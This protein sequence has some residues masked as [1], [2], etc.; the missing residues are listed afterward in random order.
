MFGQVQLTTETPANSA[1]SVEGRLSD[2]MYIPR[3]GTPSSLAVLISHNSPVAF[4]VLLLTNA[5]TPSQPLIRDRHC[6]RH[7]SLQGSLTDM[8]TNSKG[9]F[10]FLDCPTTA[11]RYHSSSMAKLINMRCL[12]AT[13]TSQRA[14]Y[15]ALHSV[16]SRIR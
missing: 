14:G 10:S 5:I 6:V 8:S 11:V 7:A 12:D 3:T 15:T 13:W 9:D 2:D 1:G 16:G 4:L